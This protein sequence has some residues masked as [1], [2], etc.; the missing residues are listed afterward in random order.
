MFRTLEWLLINACNNEDYAKILTMQAS[1]R[2]L[3]FAHDAY[4]VS[5]CCYSFSTLYY[6]LL[7]MHLVAGDVA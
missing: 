2:H 4:R 7:K 6:V 3:V 5:H 1:S